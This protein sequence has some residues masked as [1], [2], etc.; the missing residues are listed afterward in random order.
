[1]RGTGVGAFRET[2]EH[3]F[4]LRYSEMKAKLF[5]LVIVVIAIPVSAKPRSVPARMDAYLDPYVR[6]NNFSG[7]VLVERNGRAIFRKAYGLSDREQRIPNRTETRFHVASISMQ[8]TAAAIMRLAVEGKLKLDDTVASYIPNTPGA[9]K[10]TIRDLLTQ[11]S[12]LTD[13]NSLPDYGD[14]MQHHQ[15]PATLVATIE[16]KPL[17]FEPGS[18]YVHE[19]HSAYNLLALII[20]KKTQLP[21]AQAMQQL[22]FKPLELANSGIDDDSLAPGLES[23]KGYQPEGTYGLKPATPIHWSA[24]AGNASVIMTAGDQAR[25][26]AALFTGKAPNARFRSTILDTAMRVG[27]GWFKGTNQRF[28]QTA[29]YMNGRSPGFSSFV[30]YLPDGELTV[31]VFSNIYSSATTKIGNDLAAISL[32]LPYS[33]LE[34]REPPP[35]SRELESFTGTF[36]FGPDFY[37]SNAKITLRLSGGE[38]IL[39]WPSGDISSLIPISGDQFIDRSYWEVISLE[40]GASPNRVVRYGQFQGKAVPPD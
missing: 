36:Q 1:M 13:I 12:G 2:G 21:F 38:L 14:V 37:Q 24:K 6:S 8:F 5:A 10:V 25:W 16:G 20:E 11:R 26:V 18:K 31:V 32:G 23:A 27:F 9:D 28:N 29:Y 33:S 34:I 3:F 4:V 39:R 7:V 17:L 19:E 30:L 15:T 22:V 35:T 40:P